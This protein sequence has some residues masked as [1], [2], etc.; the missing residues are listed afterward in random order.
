RIEVVSESGSP[1]HNHGNVMTVFSNSA[2]SARGP[3]MQGK[4]EL[5][6][7][8]GDMGFGGPRQLWKGSYLFSGSV[9]D[10]RTISVVNALKP[11]GAFS[12]LVPARQR[13]G[14]W[15][16]RLDF[17]PSDRIQFSFKYDY[18]HQNGSDIGVGGLALPRSE[19]HTSELQSLRHL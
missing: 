8:R 12:D 5:R 19:E 16:G 9:N 13:N 2:M 3:F 1:S 11:E 4:P 17:G 7:W 15:R 10:N 18:E 14:F 6:Q